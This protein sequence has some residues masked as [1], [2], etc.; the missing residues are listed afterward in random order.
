MMYF[1][2]VRKLAN[3]LSIKRFR[4]RFKIGFK[5]SQAETKPSINEF[6]SEYLAFI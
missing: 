2:T 3:G 4:L 6:I 1:G 5:F